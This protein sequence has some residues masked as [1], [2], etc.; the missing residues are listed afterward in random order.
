MFTALYLLHMKMVGEATHMLEE[1]TDPNKVQDRMQKLRNQTQYSTPYF[2]TDSFIDMSDQV[3]NPVPPTPNF[4][5]H[6]PYVS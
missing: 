5:P 1:F 6:F 2:T 4:V 3:P